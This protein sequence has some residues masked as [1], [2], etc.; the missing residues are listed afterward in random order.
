MKKE[1]VFI[2]IFL[3]FIS[4]RAYKISNPL[5]DYIGLRQV[6]TADIAKNFY[7]KGIN[8]LYPQY[9]TNGGKESYIEI[10]FQILPA[11]TAV[12]YKIFGFHDIIGRIIAV[13]FSAGGFIFLCLLLLELGLSYRERVSAMLVYSILPQNI[14]LSRCF[15]PEPVMLFFIITLLYLLI[16]Y[17]NRGN[18]ALLIPVVIAGALAI[19]SKAPAMYIIIVFFPLLFLCRGFF[20]RR[21]ILVF[22]LI[23]IILIPPVLYYYHS[24]RLGKAY[25][26]VG[27]WERGYGHISKWGDIDTLTGSLFWNTLISRLFNYSV[28]PLLLPFFLVGLFIQ[29][30]R[31]DF[32]SLFWLFGTA[33]SFFILAKGTIA[34]P[35]YL[36]PLTPVT[37]VFS[38]IALAET[39]KIMKRDIIP[40]LIICICLIYSLSYLG[41]YYRIEAVTGSMGRKVSEMSEENDLVLTVLHSSL[42][43]SGMYGFLEK[44]LNIDRLIYYRDKGVRWFCY[45]LTLREKY[46]PHI[47]RRLQDIAGSFSLAWQDPEGDYLIFDLFAGSQAGI[48]AL[49]FNDDQ[50]MI[51]I[52]GLYGTKA[53]EISISLECINNASEPVS[54]QV[55]R[56]GRRRA[57][58]RALPGRT[59]YR[60]KMPAYPHLHYI[61]ISLSREHPAD[62]VSLDLIHREG[63]NK[64]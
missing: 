21:Y 5:N 39:G 24:Y 25:S 8:I 62:L 13:G 56:E 12:F 2:L 18:K 36:F 54:I 50:N 29:I 53:D 33:S 38:G 58:L 45:P 6:P 19:L 61:E 48:R 28:M 41:D 4:L 57:S 23:I 26:S 35:Y 32:I 43:Y 52:K 47:R 27:I 31:R 64:R 44:T 14:Y 15:M 37:A 20:R 63:K 34:N 16:R 42:Y 11:V 55:A 46:D 7:Q 22:F 1:R 3:L 30:R 51:V 60:I 59:L 9:S 17:N 10:E 40:S 49:G